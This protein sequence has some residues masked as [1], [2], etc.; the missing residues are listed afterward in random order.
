MEKGIKK[1]V[2]I[3]NDVSGLN[4]DKDTISVLKNIRHLLFYIILWAILIKCKTLNIKMFLLDIY[5]FFEK[6]INFLRAQGIKHNNI[7]IDPG[8]GFGKI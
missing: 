3:I 4:Y 2:K 7:I 5:D 8:I 1:G 6:K